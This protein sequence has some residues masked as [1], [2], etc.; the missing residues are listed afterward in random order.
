VFPVTEKKTLHMHVLDAQDRKA[1]LTAGMLMV[2]LI[3][4]R[5]SGRAAMSF[6]VSYVMLE[7]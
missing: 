5:N 3:L 2:C 6:R 7:Y 4:M 1:K